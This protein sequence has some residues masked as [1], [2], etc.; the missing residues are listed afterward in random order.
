[1]NVCMKGSLT[2]VKVI[3][4]Y[5]GNDPRIKDSPNTQIELLWFIVSII[6]G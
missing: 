4:A 2:K 1:M 5:S 3:L 6:P